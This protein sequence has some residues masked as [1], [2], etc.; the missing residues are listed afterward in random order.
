MTFEILTP[1]DATLTSVTPRTEKH[2]DDDVFAISL[3]LKVTAP[4]T[5]LDTLA[6]GLRDS[7]YKAVEGQEQ[8]PGA[9]GLGHCPRGKCVMPEGVPQ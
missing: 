1:T 4:N 8:L 7:L 5:L 9:E 3:G 6:P 2:G